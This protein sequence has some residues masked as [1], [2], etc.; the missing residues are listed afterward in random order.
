MTTLFPPEVS[1]ADRPPIPG[2]KL[3]QD[4]IDPDEEASLAEA[5]DRL[6]WDTRWQRRIQPY[7]SAYGKLGHDAPPLPAWGR[8][9]MRRLYQD[10]IGSEPF[11]QMLVNE[12]QPGQGIA[13][14]RDYEPYGRTVA[15][16]S[17]L[18]ACVMDF[19]RRSDKQ[20]ERLLLPA[21]SLLVLSDEARYDWEHGIARRK[22]DQWHS[23]PVA[24]RRRLSI[25]FR[26]RIRRP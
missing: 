1:D 14:H 24:R 8:Q 9:L 10:G 4:Y 2:L 22:A 19:R 3:I 18:S 7:G 21:R 15:S 23:L 17:L 13:L 12:Y 5:I 26:T 25:T 11:D 6:P 20:R 16:L